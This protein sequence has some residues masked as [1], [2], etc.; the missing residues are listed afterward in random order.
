MKQ[1]TK[2]AV[3]VIS[4]LAFA[5]GG[6]FLYKKVIQP[7]M[8]KV[9]GDTGMP[10]DKKDTSIKDEIKPIP[11]SGFDKYV[12]ATKSANLNIRKGPDSASEKIGSLAKGSVIFAKQS[13][14]NG[15]HEYSEN[16][17]TLTGYISSQYIK[18]Q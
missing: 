11:S 8:R 2:T 6:Y 18:K 1:G 9:K 16:G 13:A 15:W 3:W 14:T 5:V 4:I 10:E 12:V 7:G 17:T